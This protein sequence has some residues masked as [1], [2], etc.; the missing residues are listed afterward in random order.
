MK[1]CY[2]VCVTMVFCIAV[3]LECTSCQKSTAVLETVPCVIEDDNLPDTEPILLP[4]VDWVLQPEKEGVR[5]SN[6]QGTSYTYSFAEI[7]YD[8][9]SEKQPQMVLDDTGG[10]AMLLYPRTDPVAEEAQGAVL[11]ELTTGAVL[12]SY[13]HVD[14]A[15]FLQAFHREEEDVAQ[16]LTGTNYTIGCEAA[17][18]K[19]STFI[20]TFTLQAEAISLCMTGT[21]YYDLPEAPQPSHT[22]T[23]RMYTDRIV[24]G[25][26]TEKFLALYDTATE[27]YAWLFAGDELVQHTEDIQYIENAPYY[28]VDDPVFAELQISTTADLAE[29]L[30]NFFTGSFVD[31]LL[32]RDMYVDIDGKIHVV[33]AG[34]GGGTSYRDHAFSLEQIDDTHVELVCQAKAYTAGNREPEPGVTEFRYR[35]VWV[36]DT[37][38]MDSYPR[39]LWKFV[40]ESEI[41]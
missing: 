6:L 4:D 37:W 7:A 39:L 11:L 18:A 41:S 15:Y 31:E 35:F 22:F 23:D 32:A 9:A 2:R 40:V 25:E 30:Q 38:Y 33:G 8:T 14:A 34:R 27:V 5:L 21:F 1:S 17:F 12:C 20:T 36:G 19:Q 26:D 13:D 29:Y 3:C 28:A 24:W 10:Y 16:S